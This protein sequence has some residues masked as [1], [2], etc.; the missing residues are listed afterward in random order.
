MKSVIKVIA[1]ITAIAILLGALV[2]FVRKKLQEEWGATIMMGLLFGSY[3]GPHSKQDEKMYENYESYR[4]YD[5]H[6]KCLR[7]EDHKTAEFKITYQSSDGEQK[8]AAY[9]SF[10]EISDVDNE[11]FV[12]A[13]MR[14]V[15]LLMYTRGDTNGILQN[16]DNYVD[17]FN[18]WTINKIE[19]LYCK[20]TSD[21]S[22]QK[23]IIASEDE[24][25]IK[26][27]KDC[28]NSG[29]VEDDIKVSNGYNS[30]MRYYYYVRVYF[31]ES[32][33]IYWETRVCRH[34]LGDN[35]A[36]K[37]R[38]HIDVSREV[39]SFIYHYKVESSMKNNPTLSKWISDGI[40]GFVKNTESKTQ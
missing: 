21:K 34:F 37:G 40:D 18:T 2:L 15:P 9:V 33:N 31:E 10:N 39:D 20:N 36:R 24:N 5:P 22:P 28:I 6:L 4:L 25:I 8:Q 26:D 12:F 23:T 11:Q 16:P 3:E 14:D 19:L 1:I 7:L 29:K 27:F 32:D 35:S 38:Y 30:D 13:Y 17:V